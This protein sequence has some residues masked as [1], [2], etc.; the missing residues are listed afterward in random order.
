[1]IDMHGDMV[2]WAAM[3]N[4]T[5]HAFFM[6]NGSMGH[7]M[8][9]GT[10]GG[11]NSEAY[12]I[13]SNRMV[14]GYTLMSD[15]SM[16]PIMSTNALFGSSSMVTMGMGGMNGAAG[17]QSWSVNNM[18]Q[19]AGQ[20]MMSG[21][22]FHAF[23]SGSS[24]MMGRSTVDLGTLGGTNSYAYCINDAG[25]V[26]G[27]AQ[28]GNGVYHAFMVTNAMG[29]MV[30]ML[31][32]NTLI[33]TN[34]G[35]DLMEARGMNTAGQIVGWGMHTGHTNSFLLTPVTGSTMMTSAPGSEVASPDGMISLQMQ[36]SASEPLTYQ[37]LHNGMPI[38]G[39]TN[40]TLTL[41]GMAMA[42]AGQYTV[43]ARNGVGTVASSSAVVGMFSLAMSNGM[44]RLSVAAPT[45]TQFR[46][47]YSDMVGAGV[48]WQTLPNFTLIG[49]TSEMKDT[50][51]SG[52][53]TRFYR[54]MMMP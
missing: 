53:R 40:A 43:M 37:W 26:V 4:G 15:G 42:D 20:A 50:P 27:A 25:T 1:M 8:D 10:A 18:G 9:L 28:M 23:A 24:G 31:D 36:M 21:G 16:E 17:G 6:T 32:L 35:W 12:C 41:P 44:P 13:N 46:L 30:R 34:S 19:E 22:N 33:P 5:Y 29:G 48:N 45:G 3:T 7:M 47:D 39:A 54:A 49:V 11:T 51:P 52:L 14:V 2:G 38:P